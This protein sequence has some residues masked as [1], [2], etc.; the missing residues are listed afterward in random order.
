VLVCQLAVL[1]T[2][3]AIET[4][5]LATPEKGE[6]SALLIQPA[7]S[8]HLWVPVTERQ[9]QHAARKAQD[10]RGEL[11]SIPRKRAC[12]AARGEELSADVY[13]P[14]EWGTVTVTVFCVEAPPASVQVTVMV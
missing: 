14:S 11:D 6:D 13:C 4:K 2:H 10:Y 1:P 9:H 12:R 3:D 8:S 5:F 7:D